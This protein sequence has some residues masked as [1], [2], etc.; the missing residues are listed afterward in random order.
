MSLR[1]IQGGVAAN[2]APG[3]IDYIWLDQEGNLRA[4]K[5]AI[6]IYKGSAADAEQS[7]P[8]VKPWKDILGTGESARHIHLSPCHYLPDPLRPQPSFL[9][10]CET[11]ELKGEETSFNYRAKVRKLLEHPKI[12]PLESWW[13]FVQWY[14]FEREGVAKNQP[15]PFFERDAFM[16]AERHLGACLDAGLMIQSAK[17]DD[18]GSNIWNFKVG[19]REF[20]ESLDPDQPSA[21]VA[22]DHLIIARYL[23]EK[24]A[25]EFGLRVTWHQFQGRLSTTRTRMIRAE[26]CKEIKKKVAYM[27][28]HISVTRG[29]E[30]LTFDPPVRKGDPCYIVA[31]I[32]ERL[33]WE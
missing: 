10:L 5:R 17:F 30:Y 3:L 25:R 33:T 21:L 7:I 2:A 1:V 23:M 20:P 11:R 8:E 29:A 4:K 18:P 12:A 24:I 28:P 6:P 31:D 14:G 15:D 13:G 27:V 16:V 22:T 9:V 26:G 32:L 19:F